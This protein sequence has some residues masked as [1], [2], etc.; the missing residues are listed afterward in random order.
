M[1]E[2]IKDSFSVFA[3]MNKGTVRRILIKEFMENK[4][5]TGNLENENIIQY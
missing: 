3:E 1:V 2:I 5:L 4:Y